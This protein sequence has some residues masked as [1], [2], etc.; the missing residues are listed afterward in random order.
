MVSQALL[1][2][3]TTF[4][5][6]RHSGALPGSLVAVRGLGGLGHLGIQF[7]N[8]FGYK[9]AVIGRGSENPALAKKLGASM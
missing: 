5:A 7:G 4:N 6:L 2:G 8:R 1:Q 3:V 9:V